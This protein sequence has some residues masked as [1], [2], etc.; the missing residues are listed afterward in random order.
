MG[1]KASFLF[2]D[3]V[4]AYHEERLGSPTTIC[5]EGLR[6]PYHRVVSKLEI[7]FSSG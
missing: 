4:N 2:V 6:V 1:R 7:K 3:D 5:T